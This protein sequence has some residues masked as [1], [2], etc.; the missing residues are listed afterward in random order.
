MTGTRLVKSSWKGVNICRV[1]ICQKRQE[2]VAHMQSVRIK[3]DPYPDLLLVLHSIF[4]VKHKQFPCTE[5]LPRVI[6]RPPS[7]TE[8]GG[9]EYNL[10]CHWFFFLWHETQ[11][12][13]KL[14]MIFCFDS[15][16]N[17]TI[18]VL[19]VPAWFLVYHNESPPP[20]FFLTSRLYSW[21]L[22]THYCHHYR[23][24][25]TFLLCSFG[26]ARNAPSYALS[27]LLIHP[28]SRHAQ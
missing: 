25:S 6:V 9:F 14:S 19:F 10:D 22:M 7:E 13:F 1:E 3:F 24:L 28:S 21:P 16:A 17:I 27:H 11:Q 5:V 15:P 20:F 26:S 12:C 18:T 4:S 2:L 23:S 8:R